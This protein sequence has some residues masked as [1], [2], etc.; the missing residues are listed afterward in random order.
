MTL[1]RPWVPWV[2]AHRGAS[3][4][5]PEN[6]MA[7]FRRA[8][9]M[10]A[11][12]IET[13][14][15]LSRDAR[16]VA[17]HDATL[18][19]T[20]NGRGAV[21]DFTL[22]ELR[23]LDAGSWFDA[24]SGVRRDST[25]G[26]GRGGAEGSDGGAASFAGERI[27]TLEEILAF[28]RETDVVFYFEIKAEAARG[29]ENV[30][31]GALVAA[32]AAALLA[33][34]ETARV[35]VISFDAGLLESVRRRDAT[36][37]TG[38]LVEDAPTDAVERALR[39]GARQLAPRRDMVTPALVERAHRADLQVVPWTINEPAEMRAAIAA[40]VDGIMTDYPE[41]LAALVNR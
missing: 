22:T 29:T 20:T 5:A 15:H 14:L 37:M 31:A 17:I 36:L 23:E 3:A 41:R 9:E 32:L 38:L 21:R 4:H 7:A 27:P 2:I 18:E 10:G 19:R 12:F 6:T 16:F 40:G 1:R 35:V 39:A 8:V 30:L 11:G 33:A 34:E 28:A 25:H 26:A 13:D 24:K